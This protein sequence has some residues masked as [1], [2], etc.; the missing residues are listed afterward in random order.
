MLLGPMLA[1]FKKGRI[2]RPGGDKIGRRRLDTHFLGFEKLGAQFNYDANDG[3]YYQ[4]DASN[5]RGTYMLLDEASVN[6][7]SQ[8]V[9]GCGDGRGHHPDLQCRL[10][11]LFTATEQNA[12][13]HGC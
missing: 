7:H 8:C 4:V 2:P 6:G 10:R 1:R 3:G 12:Q 13:Q 5:L 11:T 9:D